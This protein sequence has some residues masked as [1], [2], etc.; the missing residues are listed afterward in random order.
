MA[1]ALNDGPG[2]SVMASLPDRSD[3]VKVS[4]PRGVGVIPNNSIFRSVEAQVGLV[5][6]LAES[7]NHRL[8]E[9]RDARFAE[10]SVKYSHVVGSRRS[11]WQ[12]LPGDYFFGVDGPGTGC[13]LGTLGGGSASRTE[14]SA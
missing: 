6:G 14:R 4:D 7:L 9:D 13:A 11:N 5:T 8:C 10:E 12:L 3:R 2:Q 1:F